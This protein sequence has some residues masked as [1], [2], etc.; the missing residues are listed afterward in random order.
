MLFKLLLIK[1]Q[2]LWKQE[3]HRVSESEVNSMNEPELEIK[4]LKMLVI[5]PRKNNEPNGKQ[6]VKNEENLGVIS[7][8]TGETND[9][10]ESRHVRIAKR[11]GRLLAMIKNSNA[12]VSDLVKTHLNIRFLHIADITKNA[13]TTWST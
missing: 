11:I 5:K 7:V 8:K 4:D 3:L 6:S 1:E 12:S 10:I 9:K 2:N 13:G